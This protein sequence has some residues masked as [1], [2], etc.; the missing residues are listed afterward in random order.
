MRKTKERSV[1]LHEGSKGS[2][3]NS[4][5]S[6]NPHKEIWMKTKKKSVKYNHY[7]PKKAK[8]IAKMHLQLT[9]KIT[10]GSGKD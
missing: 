1:H 2:P 4:R 9:G 5:G 8:I 3:K 7:I 6:V 10:G